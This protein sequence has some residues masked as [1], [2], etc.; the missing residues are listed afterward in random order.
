[1]PATAATTISSLRARNKTAQRV[2]STAQADYIAGKITRQD[3]L[4]IIQTGIDTAKQAEEETKVYL[5]NNASTLSQADKNSL[6]QSLSQS[7][8]I[9]KQGNTAKAD[10]TKTPAAVNNKISGNILRQDQKPLT[11]KFR[12]LQVEREKNERLCRTDKNAAMAGFRAAL[13]KGNTLLNDLSNYK[14]K[15]ENSKLAEYTDWSNAT[16][17]STRR[18]IEQLTLAMNTCSKT[19]PTGKPTTQAT[20]ASNPNPAPP[21]TGTTD[22]AATTGSTATAR[23]ADP[24]RNVTN[25]SSG[26]TSLEQTT[27][28]RFTE[29]D[30][31]N[32][33]SQGDW[34]VRLSL[35]PGSPNILYNVASNQAG[36]LKPLQSTDGIIFPYT[37]SISLNYAANYEF[38]TLTHSNYKLVTYGSSSVEQ[39]TI[40]ADFTAQDTFEANYLLAVI[41]FLRSATKM[42]YGQ[43][44]VVKPGTPPPLC[45]LNGYG[46]FQFNQHPLVI[47][48]FT[49]NLPNNVNYIRAMPT[50]GGDPNVNRAPNNPPNNTYTPGIYRLGPNLKQGGYFPEPDWSVLPGGT[51]PPTYVPTS[52][53]LTILAYPVVSRNEVSNQF[54]VGEYAKGAL[55]QGSRR[56]GGGFW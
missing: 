30:A 13:Q 51:Q 38:E 7:Q 4:R 35:A 41:H 22:P 40:Q 2:I 8:S 55:L 46:E 52:I 50:V 20:S 36:I 19:T 14:S 32:L 25:S 11:D 45:F 18:E 24:P 9:V 43:D 47:T 54:S 3:A 33:A 12:E 44:N 56:Q 31:T 21:G 17:L 26:I 48:Q 1:M 29:Q 39:L 16:I 42:F 23:P 34:R 15:A 27:R 5:R 6:N 53:T 49:Y 37:P 10:V 28:Q